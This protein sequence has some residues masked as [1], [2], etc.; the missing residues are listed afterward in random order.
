GS[1]REYVAGTENAA[2]RELVAGCGN[3]YCAFNNRAAGAERDAQV[4]ELLA[5]AQSVLTA[6]GNTHYTNKLYCQ[7]SALSSRHEGDVEEQC[8]VLAER[9]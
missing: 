5:L 7:A 1:L 3:R 9:V 4:A 6:N 2:L 8:R